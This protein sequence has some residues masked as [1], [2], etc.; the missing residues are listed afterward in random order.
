MRRTL[1]GLIAF[2]VVT[3]TVL[4]LPVYA[5]PAPAPKPVSPSIDSVDLGSVAAPEDA[6]VVTADGDVVDAGPEAGVEVTSDPTASEPA[7]SSSPES[8]PSTPS[9]DAPEPSEP[10]SSR[11]SEPSGEPAGDVASSGDEVEGVP[12]LTVSQ[13]ETDVFSSVGVTWAE[14]PAVTDVTVQLRTRDA[15]GHWGEW[16]DVQQEDT[17][18][19]DGEATPAQQRRDGTAPYWTGEA[20]GIEVIVQAADGSAPAD[21]QVQLI[22]PGTSRADASLGKPR[23]NGQAHAAMLMP[24]VFSRAQWGADESIMGWDHEYAPTIKAATIHHTADSNAYNPADVPAIMRSIY[25]YHTLSLGLGVIGY[26]VLVDKFGRAWEGRSGGLDSTV[27]GAHAGGFNTGTFGVSMMGNYD[28]V[29]TTPAMI[30]TVAAL[31]AWKFSL[32]GVDPRGGT[33]LTSSGGG[34]AK[35]AAGVSVTMPTIFAHRDVGST[36][37]PGRYG[38]SHMSEIRDKVVNRMNNPALWEPVETWLQTGTGNGTQLYRGNPGDVPL[39]CDWNGDGISTIGVFRRGQFVLFDSNAQSA[40]ITADFGFGNAGDTPVCG[41]WDGDGLETVGVWRKGV[42]YLRNSNS[43]GPQDATLVF[44][45]STDVPVAG[46]WD[47]DPFDTIG[48]RRG[49]SYY[50]ANSNLR[51]A[52]DS[53]Y[54]FGLT[55]DRAVVGDW[56]GDGKDS[57]G[58]FRAS[59]FYLKS[60]VAGAAAYTVAYYGNPTDRPIAGRWAPGTADNVGVARGY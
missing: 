14:D 55:G 3:G 25:A 42:F 22:D 9:S 27:I 40:W 54:V 32:Y 10:G 49:A 35:Y 52:V 59:V 16:T 7:E 60:T 18:V 6:A 1:T 36:A 2:L 4:T 51:P 31:I 11:P 15:A 39:A 30:D 43:T 24:A 47:G 34:T 21:V 26:N 12:A 13:P 56:D 44:G 17:E 33:V 19:S 48:V 37:C 45:N 20:R 5:A 50:L 28:L 8:L 58:A 23:I 46:N 57:I 29:D 41:D 53:T 38:Y